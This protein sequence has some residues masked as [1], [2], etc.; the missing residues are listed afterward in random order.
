MRLLRKLAR[1][2]QDPPPEFVF[3][4]SEAGIA[5]ARASEPQAGFLPLAPG[6]L[7][8][9]PLKDNLREPEAFQAAVKS[10][11]NGAG[12]RKRRPAALILPDYCARVAVLDF[13]SFP[14]SPEE[15]APL[16]RFRAKKAVPFDIDSAALSFAVQHRAGT[17]RCDVVVAVVALEILARFEA[18]FRNAGLHP[19]L[20]TT[21]ALAAMALVPTDGLTVTVKAT[22]KVLA[23]AVQHGPALR[24]LRCVELADLN[25]AEVLS[26]LFPTVAFT[27]D[28]IGERPARLYLCGF[29]SMTEELR[30]VCQAELNLPAEPL[31]SRL[32]VP[33]P[34]NAGLLGYLEATRG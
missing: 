18:A 32:G 17:K 3:E 27:E 6:V 14:S 20:V 21:S 25:T 16:V 7:Q 31:R 30:Q 15:Q 4:I 34:T 28:E 5:W 12:A 23:A 2:V 26:V 13:D 11:T 10:L 8:V 24:L 1:W 19:G 9:N 29:G 33:G 22:G